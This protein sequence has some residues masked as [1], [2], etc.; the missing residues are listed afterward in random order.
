MKPGRHT[1]YRGTPQNGAVLPGG[2]FC[3]SCLVGSEEPETK[4]ADK[5]ARDGKYSLDSPVNYR[6]KLAN[7]SFRTAR[8]GLK[9][10][11]KIILTA[12]RYFSRKP[13][14]SGSIRR[15][16]LVVQRAAK[17]RVFTNKITKS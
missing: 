8:P 6:A 13:C 4:V 11:E 2:S 15:K 16:A 14:L 5:R 7:A 9:V 17:A 1:K 12:F 3:M 10:S